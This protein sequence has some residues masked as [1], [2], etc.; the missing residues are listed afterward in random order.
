[1]SGG[2]GDDE[3]SD[4]D[5]RDKRRKTRHMRQPVST[6]KASSEASHAAP[7]SFAA[8]MMAKM[9]YKEGQGLGATGKGR[10][11]P[12]ETQLRPQGA[13]LGAVKEKTKQA[14][15]EEKREAAFRGEIIEDSSEEERKRKRKL[16]EKRMM[17][18]T[19]GVGTP[20]A[21][22][23][24][25]Y[26]TATEMEAA[27]DGLEVPNVLKS[28]I[29]ATGQET[30]VLASTAG[31]MSS[32]VTMVP[33][34]TESTK[35]A[36]RA[37]RDLEAFMDEWK[38]LREREDYF[39][40]EKIQLLLEVQREQEEVREIA[41]VVATVQE[42][43]Q[44]TVEG[45]DIGAQESSWEDIIA[46]LEPLEEIF[47]DG[48]DAFGLQEIATAAIHPLFRTAMEGWEPL[49]DTNSVVPYLQRL[50]SIVGFRPQSKST[51]IALQNGDS[52]TK[53]SSK[54]TTPYE[55]MFHKYWLP[56]IRS[57]I[58]NDWDVY[59]PDPVVDIIKAWEPVLPPFIL[60]NVVDQL[61]VRRLTEAVAAW[62]PRSTHK[63]R[64]HTQ[65]QAWLFPWL[66]YLDD[67]HTNPKSTTGLLADVRRKLKAVLSS[68]DL[69]TGVL[70]G[71][72]SWG[73]VFH[74][75]LTIM[76]LRHLLP[77]LAVY[78]SENFF[79]D[80][81]DQ[82]MT[83]LEKVLE[84]KPYFAP[85]TMAQLL[86]SEFFTKWHHTLYV[87]LTSEAANFAEI[88]QWYQWWK[89]TLETEMHDKRRPTGFNELPEIAAEWNK[90]VDSINRA[91]DAI[92]NGVDVTASLEPPSVNAATQVAPSSP[93]A[94]VSTP[95][96]VATDTPTTFKDV[97]EDWCAENDLHLI[98]LRE[99][100]LQTGLPLF[101]ITASASGKGGAIVY[102][103]GDVVWA[104][105]IASGGSQS[106]VFM[107]MGLDEGLIAKAE[108]K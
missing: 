66:E 42:L 54:S 15:S 84:W 10:L 48:K 78:L 70:P 35:I 72:D 60:A 9:G 16:K 33:S 36:R 105:G 108:G 83:P 26:R 5:H 106:R 38:G 79:V 75:D 86:V 74:S 102:L 53:P 20:V 46:Q 2:K 7:N 61:I 65:P 19:N 24:P 55:T 50:Q 22:A 91:I 89:E 81:S 13:G 64:R 41:K 98:A 59:N 37:R 103:K 101:R 28:I 62:K 57:A 82:D 3:S 69:G 56:R 77:R 23:K 30:R 80:P 107:P 99:A 31:L 67:Q 44:R 18:K 88:S 100:D 6:P 87:W 68:W 97:V 40:A 8:K 17:G 4:S 90:G 11:A 49:H 25:K 94:A 52:Y 14:K 43:Q 95:K 58:T 21:R 12:I 85:N 96:H 47:H 51:E 34:E 32:G 45:S 27:A 76:L 1:M 93:A 92:E 63:H 29:D 104:R 73:H 71:L 39:E